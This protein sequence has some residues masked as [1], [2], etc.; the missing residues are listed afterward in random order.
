MFHRIRTVVSASLVVAAL[1]VS[2]SAM[3]GSHAG[4][5]RSLPSL[6]Q[7]Q[8][9]KIEAA[10]AAEQKA[11][12][13]LRTALAAQVERGQIDRAAV[14]TQIAAEKAAKASLT[15]VVESTLSA[16]QKAELAKMRKEKHD[17][18]KGHAQGGKTEHKHGAAGLNLTPEQKQKIAERMKSEPQGDRG[19]DRMV[20]R[21]DATAPVLTQAQRATLATK[22]RAN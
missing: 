13:D 22:L 19:V 17:G 15:Q 2:G 6:T 5:A 20:D 11:R 18:K 12:V 1:A 21:L 9:A 3:A 14:A 8:R 4:G 10:E 16:A 7:D